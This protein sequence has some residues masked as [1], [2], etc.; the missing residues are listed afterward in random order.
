MPKEPSAPL[1]KLRSFIDDSG[2][3]GL[4]LTWW[5][6]VVGRPGLDPGTLG[7]KVQVKALHPA[8][9]RVTLAQNAW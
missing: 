8:A 7:L 5:T 6:A 9:R 1:D 4:Y 3:V 2:M